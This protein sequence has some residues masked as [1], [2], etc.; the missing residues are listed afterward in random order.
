MTPPTWAQWAGRL[1]LES[2]ASNKGQRNT[3]PPRR[4]TSKAEAT[5][6]SQKQEVVVLHKHNTEWSTFFRWFLD[7]VFFKHERAAF[8]QETYS[9]CMYIYSYCRCAFNFSLISSWMKLY[10]NLKNFH[11]CFCKYVIISFPRN[12]Y[13]QMLHAPLPLVVCFNYLLYTVQRAFDKYRM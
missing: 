1:L 6:T 5:S 11:L 8:L 10:H 7:N 12:H 3:V 2:S 9:S 13:T 4:T